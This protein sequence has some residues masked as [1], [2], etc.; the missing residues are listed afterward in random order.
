[1][2]LALSFL[3]GVAGAVR[4]AVFMTPYTETLAITTSLVAIVFIS[5]LLG[6]VLPL[7]MKFCKIDP[8]HSSTTI[9]VIMDI[10]G[11]SITVCKYIR[12]VTVLANLIG[13]L[14]SLSFL[15][16]GR[17]R[18]RYHTG[19]DSQ[20]LCFRSQLE[21]SINVTSKHLIEQCCVSLVLLKAYDFQDHVDLIRQYNYQ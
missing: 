12:Y 11:V 9:Q 4:A 2:G 17:R 3:L 6:A 19:H 13:L 8:A 21:D 1:M 20:K 16:A 15:I 10:L 5:V 7:L 18:K 14:T